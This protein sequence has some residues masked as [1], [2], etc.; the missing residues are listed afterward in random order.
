MPRT[1]EA[2]E[3]M[4]ETTRQKIETAAL[5]L[6][7]KKGLSVTVGEIAQTAGLSKG[8][9]YSHYQSKEALIAELARQAAVGSGQTVKD[10]AHSDDT[11]AAKINEITSIMCKMLSSSQIGIDYFMF[12]MQLGMSGFPI[13][14]AIYH[15]KNN[16]HPIESLAQIIAQGQSEQSVIDGNPVQLA[17]LYWAAIQGLCCF[18]S[19]GVPFSPHPETISRILLKERN[20]KTPA[21]V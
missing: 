4:R 1:K 20:V 14:Q 6:F 12:M 13:P 17:V 7:A 19:T 9:L 16:P 3:A 21:H 11:A 10:I 18:I 2:F 8:L 15:T 5:S